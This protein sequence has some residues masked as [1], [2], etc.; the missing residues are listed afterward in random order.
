MLLG[1]CGTI[2]IVNVNFTDGTTGVSRVIIE[3]FDREV[4]HSP[5]DL[6]S[7]VIPGEERRS[8][9]N[10]HEGAELALVVLKHKFAVLKLDL[11][12]ASAH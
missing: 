8:L 12:V 7:L 4:N 3:S 9:F 1:N 5:A 2:I 11:G 6:H 10:Q